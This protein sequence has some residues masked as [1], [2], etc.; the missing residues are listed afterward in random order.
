MYDKNIEIILRTVIKAALA[1][2]AEIFSV[3]N[4]DKKSHSVKKDGTPVTKADISSS[5]VI[6]NILSS[7][8]PDIPILCEET[9]ERK[10]KD[11]VP[12]RIKANRCFIVDPLDGTK[13]FISGNDE[14]AVSIAYAEGNSSVAGVIFAPVKNVLYYAASNLGAYRATVS[15]FTICKSVS[16]KA[17]DRTNGLVAL[18]SRGKD[19]TADKLYVKYRERISELRSVGS[20]LKGCLIAEGTADIYYKFA[21]YTKEWDT[22]AEQI[23]AEEAGA[24]VTDVFG[25]KL[26]VNRADVSNSNGIR[27]LNRFESALE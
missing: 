21:P 6:V 20:C 1:G 9:A 3:W 15:D 16:I 5:E 8:C 11:G 10:D 22:A 19:A 12:Q 18:C 27:I 13:E 26:N 23:I 25:N 4:E 24:I 7:E 2:G 17:S 14:F